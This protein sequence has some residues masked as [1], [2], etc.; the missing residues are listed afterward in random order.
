MQRLLLVLCLLAMAGAAQGAT[1]SGLWSR[2]GY[3]AARSNH[4]PASTGITAANVR[5]LVR[6]RV[7][8]DGTVDSSPILAG[9]LVVVTTSYGKTIAVDPRTGRI[10]WRFTPPGYSSWAGS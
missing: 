6:Q 8:L 10:R 2:F 3:D 9:G 1:P 7:V 5:R 4:G